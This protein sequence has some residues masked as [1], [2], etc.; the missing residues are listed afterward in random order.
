[1]YHLQLQYNLVYNKPVISSLSL[2]IEIPQAAILLYA[3]LVRS[4]T[5]PVLGLG[6]HPFNSF[7]IHYKYW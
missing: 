3:W 4:L 5:A 2:C 7:S 6:T 1:M